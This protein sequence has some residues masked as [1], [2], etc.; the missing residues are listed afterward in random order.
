MHHFAPIGYAIFLWWFS[1][2]IIFY[3]DALPV[4][5]FKWSMAGATAVLLGSL[6]GLWVTADDTSLWGAY[7][8]FSCGL[9]AW[10][11]QEISLYMGYVTGPRQHRCPAGCSGWKHFGHAIQVNLW[12][13]LAIIGLAAIIYYVVKDG[14]NLLGFWTYLALWLMHLSA[15]LN[16][17]LGVR[18]VSEEFVPPH[19]DVLKSFLTRKP[20]NLLFPISVT[21]LTIAA[22]MLFM[23]AA[24]ADTESEAAGLML[25]GALMALAILE[26]WLLM[27]PLPVDRIW[28]WSK[29]SRKMAEKANDNNPGKTAVYTYKPLRAGP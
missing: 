13:E 27:V 1:T 23:K 7:V 25:I 12:H 29:S 10:G 26:H 24:S 5:T 21:V 8:A 20:M 22:V 19:M 28:R 18:N 15:R 4:K 16:V 9:L 6:Y 17:F 3:L 14:A 11:W 2:G